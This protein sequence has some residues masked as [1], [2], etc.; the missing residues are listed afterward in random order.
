MNRSNH[1]QL[2]TLIAVALLPAAALAGPGNGKNGG[3]PQPADPAAFHPATPEQVELGRALFF[4]KLISGNRNI[5]CATCHHPLAGTGDVLSLS[6]GEGGQGLGTARSTGQGGTAIHERVPRNAP[7]IFNLGATSFTN[8]FHDG[9][10]AVDPS[11]PSGFLNPAGNQLPEGLESALAAQA[12]FPVTSGTEM[13]GQPGE[14]VIADVAAAGNL[15]GPG[16]VWDLLAARLQGVPEYVSLFQAAFPEQV[17]VPGDITFVHAA[18]AI[19]AYENASYRAID[20][21]FD[22]KLRGEKKIFSKREH[23]GL[24]LFYGKAGCADCHSGTYLTDLDFHAI[25]MPQIGPGKG[26]GPRFDDDWGRGRETGL[27]EDRYKFRTPT[28]RNVALTGPWGHDGAYD[29]LEAVVR[30]HLD[31]VNGL[32]TYDRSQALLPPGL[33]L[34]NDFLATDDPLITLAIANANELA[35]VNL[36]DQEVDDLIAFLHTLTDTSSLDLRSQVPFTVPSGLPIGD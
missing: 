1:R 7:A 13:A 24:K 23:K 12:M 31:P 33:Q 21:R 29:S 26:D 9:R 32:I 4:D 5:S 25:A 8:M 14:N 11:Q 15:A 19:A 34:A 10:I 2:S 30:H 22:K 28:L 18:N 27:V 6:V 35:P 3:L 20:S 36:K 17:A 16:G